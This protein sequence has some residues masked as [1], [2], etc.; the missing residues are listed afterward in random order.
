MKLPEPYQRQMHEIEEFE[1]HFNV[2]QQQMPE[3][4]P[5]RSDVRFSIRQWK[6]QVLIEAYNSQFTEA[7]NDHS[8]ANER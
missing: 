5:D 7:L 8:I 2:L 4:I 3:V 6:K 1:T